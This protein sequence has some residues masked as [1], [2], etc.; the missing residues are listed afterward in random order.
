MLKIKILGVRWD[1]GQEHR[2]VDMGPFAVRAAGLNQTLQSLGH[3]VE[4]GG[5]VPVRLPE[6]QHFGDQNA[7]Y[8]KE[9]AETSQEVAQRV[10]QALEAGYFPLLLG[11][12]HSVAIGTQAGV[13]KFYRDRH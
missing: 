10:Y 3:Q 13:S 5:N 4:D 7:K 12:D 6:Q 2:G 1:L 8:L 11:G 9:I